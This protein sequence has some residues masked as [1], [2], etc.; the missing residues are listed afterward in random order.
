MS[1]R[2]ILHFFDSGTAFSNNFQDVAI[3]VAA[4]APRVLG[5]WEEGCPVPEFANNGPVAESMFKN[6]D[7]ALGDP[8]HFL[9]GLDRIFDC[10]ER[11][12]RDDSVEIFIGKREVFSPGIHEGDRFAEFTLLD[13]VFAYLQGQ[14]V[15]I[16]SRD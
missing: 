2:T 3:L 13:V 5:V 14:G 1:N 11:E 8:G 15:I 16:D 10:T 4:I 12:F 9:N 7:A 6:D